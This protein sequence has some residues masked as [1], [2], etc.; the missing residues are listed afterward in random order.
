VMWLLVDT[1]LVKPLAF[2]ALLPMIAGG[3][4]L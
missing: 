4:G 3:K 1:V 2:K